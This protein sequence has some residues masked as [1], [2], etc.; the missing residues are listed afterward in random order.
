[1]AGSFGWRGHVNVNRLSDG[2]L[3]VPAAARLFPYAA[4]LI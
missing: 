4:G 3:T 2:I 1:M